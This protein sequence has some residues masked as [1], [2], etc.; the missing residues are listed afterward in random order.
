[1]FPI[2]RFFSCQILEIIDSQIETKRIF[3]LIRILTNL[4][5]CHLQLEKLE[6]LNFVNKN[7]PN[8]CRVGCKSLS[9]FLEHIGIDG[10]LEEELKQFERVF[11]KDEI[12]DLQ[13][14]ENI[15]KVLFCPKKGKKRFPKKILK[16][17]KSN[18]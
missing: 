17:L 9:N 2:V 15:F 4:R 13:I 6:K 3:S 5:G 14:A 7:W 1:M 10:D 18:L 11:E 16:F 8:D 12:V